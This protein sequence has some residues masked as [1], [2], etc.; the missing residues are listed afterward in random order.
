[1]PDLA[2]LAA[3]AL[4][5]GAEALFARRAGRSVYGWSD[6]ELSLALLIGWFGTAL[7][8]AP[9]IRPVWNASYQPGGV[10]PR[11]WAGVAILIVLGDFLHYWS[12]RMSHSLR[13]MWAAH[14]AH[15]SATRLNFLAAFRQGWTDF[16][17]GVWLF[18]LPLGALGFPPADWAWYFA[19]LVSWQ[20]WNH[21]EWCGRLGPLEWIVVTP[22]HHRVHH[23]LRPEHVDRN[24]GGIFILWDRLFGT[25]V[26]EGDETVR[27][28]GLAGLEP[29][30]G[31]VN[32]AFREWQAMLRQLRASRTP[33]ALWTALVRR[34]AQ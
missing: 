17:A 30:A 16:P 12:H 4:A 19:A 11:G 33:A 6:T 15:H 20:L 7:L 3:A 21:N 8:F 31:P 2:L 1:M 22:S 28:F 27:D 9:L 23:S 14:L 29:A 10:V 25:F 26:P 5:I 34:A 32:I 24:F 13:W 18:W